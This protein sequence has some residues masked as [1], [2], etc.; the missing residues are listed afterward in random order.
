MLPPL[1]TPQMDSRNESVKSMLRSTVEKAVST[2]RATAGF[3]AGLGRRETA[4]GGNN[5]IQPEEPQREEEEYEVEPAQYEGYGEVLPG[6]E[7]DYEEDEWVNGLTLDG[8]KE[9]NAEAT[10]LTTM[11]LRE[12]EK[13]NLKLDDKK[14]Q[15]LKLK[16]Q[17]VERMK[18]LTDNLESEMADR[19]EEIGSIKFMA[20]TIKTSGEDLIPQK[21]LL[22]RKYVES[23]DEDGM[24]EKLN[25]EINGLMD[26]LDERKCMN[27]EY[28]PWKMKQHQT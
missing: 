7:G 12:V 14:S 28:K 4:R 9:H 3:A 13:L 15:R 26:E 22:D 20:S 11:L 5:V 17:C 18:A 6:G 19:D 23:L 24:L 21:K 16:A 25:E 10:N 8:M 27:N 2:A 1:L